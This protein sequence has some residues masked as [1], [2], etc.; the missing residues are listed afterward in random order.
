MTKAQIISACRYYINETSTDTGALLSDTGN[1]LD[2]IDDSLEEVTLEL[3]SIMPLQLCTTETITLVANQANYT[4]T[5]TGYLQVY[6]V[7]RY[8]TG[9]PPTQI[10][11]IDPLDLQDHTNIGDTEA[12]PNACYFIGDVLWL[13]KTPTTAKEYV[14][15]WLVQTEL[16][17]IP[18]AGPTYLPRQT[19]RL[20]VY[21]TMMNIGEL[22][23]ISVGRFERLY[24]HRLK[25]ISRVWTGKFQQE[26]RFVRGSIHGSRTGDARDRALFDKTGYFDD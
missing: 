21:R 12:D 13:V 7:E 8:E 3:V 23:G 17:T 2:F 11:I 10:E 19:H 24:N 18:T 22:A 5:T 6:K 9:Q 15:L 16:A 1:L 20:I 14:R 4:P 25:N 26:P